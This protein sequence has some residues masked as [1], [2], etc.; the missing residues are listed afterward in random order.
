MPA[1]LP[2][3]LLDPETIFAMGNPDTD[4]FVVT[5]AEHVC[6]LGRG[7]VERNLDRLHPGTRWF[8][9]QGLQVTLD[10]YLDARR[11]RFGYVRELDE[12]LGEEGVV[13]SPTSAAEGWLAEEGG[14]RR[15]VAE[16]P[17][18]QHDPGEQDRTVD[19]L[20]TGCAQR[21]PVH[22]RSN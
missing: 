14:H 1:I 22:E 6:S 16:L 8:L 5:T 18:G 12:M 9:E 13:L 3:E 19:E 10:D 20:P 4:W 11:R 17:G 21:A 7:V 15:A 2:I